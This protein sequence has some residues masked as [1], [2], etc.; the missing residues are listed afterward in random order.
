[1]SDQARK[2][3]H[4]HE[5]HVRGTPLVLF[6]VWDAGS[7]KAV[8]AGGAKAIAP[9]VTG[10]SRTRTDPRTESSCRFPL[11]SRICGGSSARA[12]SR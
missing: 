10:R 1:M 9:R 8:S 12:I 5:L 7:A 4:F 11:R 2:A 3:R 6:N